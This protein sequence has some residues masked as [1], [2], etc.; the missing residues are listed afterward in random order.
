MQTKKTQ[1]CLNNYYALRTSII[2]RIEEL[3][4]F[5]DDNLN[6]N[7]FIILQKA[8]LKLKRLLYY[9]PDASNKLTEADLSKFRG[10]VIDTDKFGIKE[11]TIKTNPS[12]AIMSDPRFSKSK[13][14][15]LGSSGKSNVYISAFKPY[16]NIHVDSSQKKDNQIS[17]GKKTGKNI[18]NSNCDNEDCVMKTV[19]IRLT[20][21]EYKLLEKKR[22]EF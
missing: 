5:Y 2:K 21:D 3:D 15:Q 14:N 22:K 11:H 12:F 16:S 9:N 10:L 13:A 4:N 17:S 18:K 20:A 8:I 1:Q 6:N 19:K 7:R